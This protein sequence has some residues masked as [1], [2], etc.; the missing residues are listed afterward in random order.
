MIEHNTRPVHKLRTMGMVALGIVLGGHA[1][2]ALGQD[3][4]RER[5]TTP[6][7]QLIAK[8][9]AACESDPKLRGAL[10]EGDEPQGG[11]LSLKGTIDRQAQ[12][13]LIEEEAKR[14]LEESPAWKTD[15]PGGASASKMI[16]FPIRSELLPKLRAQ[17]AKASADPAGGPSLFRQTRID[18]LY[19]DAQGC[20]R[21]DALCINQQ[22]YLAHN[23]PAAT[24]KE[25]TV[26]RI[27]AEVLK[28]LSGCP[29][30]EHVDRKV[31]G[32]LLP[33]RLKFEPD[34]VRILQR[35]ANEA[36]LDDVLFREAWFDS[37]GQLSVDGLLGDGKPD[38]RALAAEFVARPEIVKAYARPAD[39]PPM[40]PALVV[41]PMSAGPWRR[42]LIAA[43]QKRFASD[44]N[45]KGSLSILRHC[46][47]D[48]AR[49]AYSPDAGLLLEFEIVALLSGNQPVSPVYAPLLK[50]S[51]E[52]I[53]FTP[54]VRPRF[55]SL[56]TPLPALQQKVASTP[57][58]DGVRLDDLVFGPTGKATLVGRWIGPSQAETIDAVLS[59][60]VVELSK[61]NVSGPLER[62]LY[63]LPTDRLL[64]S[65]RKKLLASPTETS[66]DR[67]FF[68]P[69]ADRSARPEMVLQGATLIT[70]LPETRTQI[71]E[72]LKTDDLAKEVGTAVVELL[73]RPKSLLT[74]LR[75]L[76]ALD[77]ALDG[78]LVKSAGFDLENN[79]VLA[80]R[81]DHEGQAAGAIALIPKAAAAAWNGLPPP[82][83]APEGA[84]ANF[85]LASL[86]KDL[87]SK[88]QYYSESDG[89]MLTRAYYD[90]TSELVLAGRVSKPRGEYSALERR[91]KLLLGDDADIKLASLELKRQEVDPERK[92]KIV[93]RGAQA[94]ASGN[95]ASFTQSDLE[96]AVYLAPGES[97]TW[98]L[99]G[100]YYYLS[101]NQALAK[102]DLGRA[103]ALE[104]RDPALSHD[105]SGILERFQ[106]P[107]RTT[108]E[109]LMDAP[110]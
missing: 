18:D 83:A 54:G 109:E 86:L 30:P 52:S 28:Q 70:S 42:A 68:R 71:E 76:V 15:L 22:A 103:H 74:E 47:I 11:V 33:G 34:P 110:P 20:L 10:V 3:A 56:P 90:A 100:A 96:E 88:L 46:R 107:L 6:S 26:N 94:L 104:K 31:M 97:T 89:V 7:Q 92:D 84:F 27:V 85:P 105:R 37:E 12:A 35:Y 87:S 106:A 98:Y 53:P 19:F 63:E 82:E 55:T 2:P 48:R 64:K 99:R 75:K 13:G 77:S 81:Q 102:R 24:S 91:I 58:L 49:F 69:A 51:K 41:S 78:V 8:L 72:W 59:P 32:R 93:G 65:L 4:G 23:K 38:E 57:A 62:K 79:L 66:L 61:G 73:P 39:Q 14:L 1:V 36:K 40:K 45:S 101:G 21:V 80:G 17:F 60:L 25:H 16:V 50:G 44:A 29:A 67:L 43:L 9:R 95:L 108:L 5:A